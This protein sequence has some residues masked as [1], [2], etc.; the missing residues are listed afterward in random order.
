M[1]NHH[2][3]IELDIPEL[4]GTMF[5][6]F[7]KEVKLDTLVTA[8]RSSSHIVHQMPL[9]AVPGWRSIKAN[10]VIHRNGASPAKPGIGTGNLAGANA[11]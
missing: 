9:V 5:D 2:D 4:G 11:I 3:Q 7:K 1:K 6:R 8:R 10:V